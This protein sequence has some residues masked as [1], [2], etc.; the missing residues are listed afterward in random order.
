[1]MLT[2][3]KRLSNFLWPHAGNITISDVRIGL[4][5][6]AVKLENGYGGVAWTP[7]LAASCCTHFAKAGTLAGRPARELLTMLADEHSALARAVGL[8]AAN[9]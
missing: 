3:Q 2:V 6:T 1:M 8:A 9:A 7:N 5:Y 4:G